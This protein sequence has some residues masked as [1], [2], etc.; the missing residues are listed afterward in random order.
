MFRKKK[1]KEPMEIK[2]EQPKRPEWKSCRFC[3]K[4][5]FNPHGM[6]GLHAF[7][8]DTKRPITGIDEW[9]RCDGFYPKNGCFTCNKTKYCKIDHMNEIYIDE[10]ITR[11]KTDNC[12][13]W[14]ILPEIQSMLKHEEDQ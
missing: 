2:A 8:T 9:D 3:A 5:E 7:C 4:C 14:V 12:S 6:G 13:S 1:N 10:K 11:V